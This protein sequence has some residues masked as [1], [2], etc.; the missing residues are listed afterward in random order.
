MW[1]SIP[2]RFIIIWYF[3]Y[4]WYVIRCIR[5]SLL[6]ITLIFIMIM[7]IT[8]S[9]NII[10]LKFRNIWIYIYTKYVRFFTSKYASLVGFFNTGF[11][12]FNGTNLFL[13]CFPIF[14]RD[15][16]VIIIIP[17]IA[18]RLN[19]KPITKRADMINKYSISFD[20]WKY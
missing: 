17:T 10:F 15:K 5:R 6:I 8:N 14:F 4:P 12:G 3:T 19:I 13:G 9:I 16:F 11:G 20:S 18:K 7:P 1:S 2:C